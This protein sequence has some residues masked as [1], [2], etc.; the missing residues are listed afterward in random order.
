MNTLFVHIALALG[1]ITVVANTQ[2][3]QSFVPFSCSGGGTGWRVYSDANWGGKPE[4]VTIHDCSGNTVE[5]R[6]DGVGPTTHTFGSSNGS[7]QPSAPDETDIDALSSGITF[8]KFDCV[9]GGSGW[10]IIEDSDG[11]GKQDH[12]S[13]RHCNGWIESRKLDGTGPVTWTAPSSTTPAEQTSPTPLPMPSTETMRPTI[14]QI[15]DL[16]DNVGFLVQVHLLDE[17]GRS[18]YSSFTSPGAIRSGFTLRS[19]MLRPGEY[20]FNILSEDGSSVLRVGT[21]S[22]EPEE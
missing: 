11:D 5:R 16:A 4:T 18:A 1:L 15:P 17:N 10:K 14:I 19:T 12:I 13:I 2:S 20:T 22:L 9:L 6:L 8:S 21:I 7:A 3:L